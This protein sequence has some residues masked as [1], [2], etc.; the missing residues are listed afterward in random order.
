MRLMAIP[1]C[2]VEH[3]CDAHLSQY[4]YY[5]I[6]LSKFFVFVRIVDEFRWYWCSVALVFCTII[7]NNE[8]IVNSQ[9][10]FFKMAAGKVFV[11]NR[12]VIVAES[13][14]AMPWWSA[15]VVFST[16]TRNFLSK[17]S[18][19]FISPEKF[20]VIRRRQRDNWQPLSVEKDNKWAILEKK[21]FRHGE[22]ILIIINSQIYKNITY[23]KIFQ[24]QI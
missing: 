11:N 19:F 24:V 18:G 10:H 16:T 15:K 3:C 2:C 12:S 8:W 13:S 1:H 20:I 21:I 4:R 14:F 6:V 9:F 17:K 23:N 7:S 22:W 5:F